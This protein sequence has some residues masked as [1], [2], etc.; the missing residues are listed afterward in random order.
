MGKPL[1]QAEAEVARCATHIDYSKDVSLGFLEDEA[2]STRCTHKAFLTCAPIGPFL[3]VVPWNFP[4]WVPF[5]SMIPPLVLGNPI[6]MKHAPSTPLCAEALEQLFVDAGFDDGEYQNLY[7][8]NE[9]AERVLADKR[10]RGVKFTGSTVGGKAVAEVAGRHM[11]QG[12]YELG[13]SDPFCVLEDADLKFAVEKAYA[14]RMANNGQV[15][16]SAKRFIVLDSVYEEFRD[17]LIQ[18]LE[19]SVKMGDPM[20]KEGV[21]L[22]PLAIARL[23]E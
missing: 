23:T 5:K 3:D 19:E 12:C 1:A 17:L 20:D 11:K 4:F 7:I 9:Q 10:V 22:G 8:T 18:K 2:L 16:I 6:L 21:T 15:C 13:G 14:S